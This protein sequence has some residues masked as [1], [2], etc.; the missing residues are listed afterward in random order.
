MFSERT[1]PSTM[2]KLGVDEAVMVR[3]HLNM[4]ELAQRAS[5]GKCHLL[6]CKK[7]YGDFIPND[8]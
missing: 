7:I 4:I 6:S 3:R 5:A 2:E 1:V 8:G